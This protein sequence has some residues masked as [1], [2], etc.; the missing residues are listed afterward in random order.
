M[1]SRIKPHLI[2]PST[3]DGLL[4]TSTS[5][6]TTW[7]GEEGT[8]D[9]RLLAPYQIEP[10]PIDGQVITTVSGE[11]TWADAPAGGGATGTLTNSLLELAQTL[12]TGADTPL[13]AFGGGLAL[14]AGPIGKFS[15][16]VITGPVTITSAWQVDQWFTKTQ[17]SESAWVIVKGDLTIDAGVIFR[18]AVRKLF[19]MV[20]VTGNLI[21]NGQISMTQRGANHSDDGWGVLLEPVAL[22]VKTGVTIPALGGDGGA[23][24]RA[25]SSGG[26]GNPGTSGVASN[27]TGGGGGGGTAWSLSYGGVDAGGGPGGQG[28]CYSGGSGGGGQ[29]GASK[30]EWGRGYK[31]GGVGGPTPGDYTGGGGGSG[32]G[33]PTPANQSAHPVAAAAGAAT[34]SSTINA[35]SGTGGTLI[36]IVGGTVSGTGSL[37]AGGARGADNQGQ[38][39]AGGGS[40]GGCIVQVTNSVAKATMSAPGGGGGG[41]GY[42]S[43]TGGAGG[44]GSTR[45]VPLT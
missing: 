39:A 42:A 27:G 23:T 21:L 43:G 8:P 5:G 25:D 2:Q 3:T 36:V 40:G 35:S 9:M 14:P 22:T 30:F 45:S 13:P 10:S 15:Y 28:T 29:R 7:D 17:D 16:K 24:K 4:L 41:T 11:T 19:T 1:P 32:A 26:A 6:T 12:A 37:Q 33:N 34:W 20:Y 18:P 38:V 44:A 31:Y